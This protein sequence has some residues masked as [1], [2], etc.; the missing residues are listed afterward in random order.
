MDLSNELPCKIS[1]FILKIQYEISLSL[2]IYSM[3][4]KNLCISHTQFTAYG[5]G[6]CYLDVLRVLRKAMRL[7]DRAMAFDGTFASP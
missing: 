6:P 3:N 5:H 2:I 7:C 1:Y 4:I